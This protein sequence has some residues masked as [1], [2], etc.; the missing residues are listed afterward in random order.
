MN[1]DNSQIVSSNLL[2]ELK[3]ILNARNIKQK[4]ICEALELS[5][6]YTSELMNEKK[7]ISLAQ[8]E[9]LCSAFN[10]TIRLIDKYR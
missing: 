4:D 6:S 9:K 10:I 8:F 7:E 1:S 5:Q 2:L 3:N